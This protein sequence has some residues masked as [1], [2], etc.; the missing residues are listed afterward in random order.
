MS[1]KVISLKD[2]A[3]IKLV[4]SLPSRY[5]ITIHRQAPK[6]TSY[7]LEWDESIMWE[8]DDE[9]LYNPIGEALIFNH[10]LTVIHHLI[11]E[12]ASFREQFKDYV[13]DEVLGEIE[14]DSNFNR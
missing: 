4:N 5:N 10:V 11:S 1:N 3:Y 12:D 9:A 8:I 6:I 13:K 7:D 14:H 2:K